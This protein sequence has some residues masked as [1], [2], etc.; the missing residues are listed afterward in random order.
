MMVPVAEQQNDRDAGKAVQASTASIAAYTRWFLGRDNQ[1]PQA[2]RVGRE[3]C[4]WRLAVRKTVARFADGDVA[5][6]LLRDFRIDSSVLCRSVMAAPWG[7]GVAGR[8]AGSFHMVLEGQGWLEV[9]GGTEPVHL[10]AGDLAVLPTG[11][12]HW[13]KDSPAT[14]AP[15]LTSILARH[16]VVDGELR[17]G[18]DGGP[19]TEIVC[20]VFTL[21]GA[22]SAP[23]IE[24]LPRIVVS[25]G[26]TRGPDWRSAATAA[27][28]EEAHRPTRGGAALVN[29]LL[30]SLLADVL[31]TELAAF[32]VD[33]TPPGRALADERIGGVL[34]RLHERPEEPW[35]VGDL[36]RMAAM[37]RSAFSER[38]RLLVGEPPM[39]YLSGLRLTRATRLLR[40]T[41][42]TVAE[43]A[44]RVGYGSE[45]ALSRAFKLRFGG[46]PSV[47]RRRARLPGTEHA[48]GGSGT[49]EHPLPGSG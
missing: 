33:A 36:A 5:N 45:E 10:R 39:R 41:D 34:A 26:E 37:S 47:I 43:I 15:S 18:G 27:L 48:G 49:G 24:R 16:G 30:E 9:E 2:R 17:F 3:L 12:A 7:F 14:T 8:D 11:S 40:S 6:E 44:R 21:E 4:V 1:P 19:L 46:A 20:G 23:W 35:T 29:R 32:A 22:R 31:R 38:F 42:T 25:P 13:V 28:R